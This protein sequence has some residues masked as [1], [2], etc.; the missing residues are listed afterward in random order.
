MASLLKQLFSRSYAQPPRAKRLRDVDGSEQVRL[1]IVLKPNA[2][3]HRVG[4]PVSRGEYKARFATADNVIE[5]ITEYA[6]SHGLTVESAN[7]GHHLMHLSGTYDQ[8]R[9]AFAPDNL[10]VY[11]NGTDEFVSRHG[12]LYVPPDF[13]GDIVA[14]MGFDQRPIARP[15]VRIR[16]RSA[17][18]ATSYD[19]SDVARR[20]QF[21]SGAT[22]AGQTIALIELGGGYDDRQMASYFQAK[23]VDRTGTL[24]AVSVDGAEN[25]P[26]DA[27][28]A[29]G[30]VQLDVE[31]A[32]SVAP[33]AN[34]AVYF[35]TNQSSGFLNAIASAVHD[36]ENAPSVISI[37]WG[38]PE[39]EWPSQDIDAMNQAFQAA[40]TLGITVCCAA[41][42]S[43]A[44]DG[45]SGGRLTVDF[46][47]SSPYVLGCGGTRLPPTGPETAWN[48]GPNG[49]ASGGGYSAVFSRPDWQT[50]TGPALQ[51]KPGR[52]VPDVAGDADP[53]TGYNVAVDGEAT[54]AGGT[55]AVAPLWA[56]LVA[57]SNQVAGRN[58]GFVNPALYAN[59]GALTDI[60]EGNNNGYSA[61]PGWDPIT[62]LGSPLGEAVA[63]ALAAAPTAAAPVAAALSSNPAV[64]PVRAVNLDQPLFDP[65][66]YGN[67]PQDSVTDATESA[68]ITH[69][70]IEIAGNNLAYTATAGHLV[71]VDASSSKPNAKIFYVA[72]VLDGAAR[73]NRPVTF[74]Y[75]GG[76]GSSS[77]YVLLG[78]F[79]PMR[80]KTSL[81]DF[82]PPA[83]YTI[84]TNPDSL[85][86]RSDLVFI[87]PVGTGYSAAIAPNV[88][89]DFWGADKDAASIG[90]FI[91]RYLTANDRWNSPKF[92][93]GESYG[94]A[95]SCILAY[96]LHEDG[97]ELNGVTL[98]SSILDYTQ[99]GN[100]IGLLPTYAADAWYHEK[101]GPN[102]PG[103]LATYLAPVITFADSVYP[104]ALSQFPKADPNAVAQ[105]SAY[106][107]IDTTTL[108]SWSL[109]VAAADARGTSLFLTT[110]LQDKGLALGSYDGRATGVNTGIAATI[111]PKSGSN[112]PT[113]TAVN[114]V[115]T[116][117]WN[118]Y[119]NDQLRYT[120]NSAFTDL[121]DQAFANWDFSHIDPTGAQKGIDGKGNVILYTAGDLAAIMSLNVD[122]KVFSAN[123][124]YDSVTPFH[125]TVLD[126]Q[127]MPL[128]DAGLR[129]N[130]TIRFFPS[131]H[132]IYLD[133]PS[134]TAMK[135]DLAAFYD[136]AVSNHA[137]VMRIRALQVRAT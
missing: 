107:G 18:R 50:G 3:P 31:I 109:N 33:G 69:H 117:M 64:A 87:N 42:D 70:A 111:D 130:L 46:P 77:V 105:L 100:P 6:N 53:A 19:P 114:G 28:G 14:V 108:D 59:P 12:H 94:T 96:M 30:E 10:A 66:A 73:D 101:V 110:L 71:T 76:P 17:A 81:P 86:D 11:G 54:V 112:D 60:T 7:A 127:N 37:S 22:G 83:P 132:M 80:I 136:S 106:I 91:K 119:L 135:S 44:T 4:A 123:G 113:M 55:S 48:D 120:S 121:N 93:F 49:G 2:M 5:R 116:A 97:V 43:G 79:A 51:A 72:F 65:V 16:P 23:G 122:L 58:A 62:G 26:G 1:T 21:P 99:A 56:G 38:G 134:R 115:Y 52:G 35:T 90:Q 29:D 15:Y 125:Q 68:A 39:T 82:T 126:L 25:S 88:N 20:Y 27:N 74:F 118:T 63:A 85:L 45:A 124:Y 137:A 36:T 95:R 104:T 9:S 75:N 89:K 8:A 78:S 131:G 57:L 92:L 102:R 40:A 24:S 34:I 129:K 61:G 98:Q 103:D 47:A 32:G 67:G 13:A 133:G 128:G 41:G 84:E